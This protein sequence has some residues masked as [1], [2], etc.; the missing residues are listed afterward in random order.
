MATLPYILDENGYD[1]WLFQ[2]KKHGKSTV[3]AHRIDKTLQR[4]AHNQDRQVI[5]KHINHPSSASAMD[6][7]N[8]SNG[9][10]YFKI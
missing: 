4:D 9:N 8:S 1:F 5:K 10:I 3:T 2:V 6:L 7:K